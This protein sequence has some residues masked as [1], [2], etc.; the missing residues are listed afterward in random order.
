M[1]ALL[2]LLSSL[3]WGSADFVGGL[4]ARRLPAFAVVAWA[5]ACALVAVL[6]VC[7][8]TGA[9]DA[10]L[11]YLPWAIAAGFVGTVSLAAFYAALASGTMGVVAPI[12]ASGVVV[13]VAIGLVQGESPSGVQLVGIVAAVVGIILASGPELRAVEGGGA[14]GGVRSLV[15]AGVAAVGF[16]LVLWLIG[17]AAAYSVPMTLLTQRATS[18]VFAL[19]VAAVV[20]SLGGVRPRDLPVL[21]VVGLGDVAANGAFALAATLGLLS[22]V[23][24]LGSLYPVATVLLARFVLHERL[25]RVQQVG[26]SVALLGVILLGAG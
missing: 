24:V 18:V 20:G 26:V 12:A 23:S 11:G 7:A 3:L 4:V 16:G 14:R 6:V 10:P 15:L 2:A 1:A 13:P 17:E 5:Q 25:A 21:S 19:V 22:V 9:F 8:A